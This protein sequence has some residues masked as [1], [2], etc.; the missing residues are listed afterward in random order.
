M[1]SDLQMSTL[2]NPEQENGNFENSEEFFVT[3]LQ[4]SQS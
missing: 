1:V 2:S 4:T 3:A